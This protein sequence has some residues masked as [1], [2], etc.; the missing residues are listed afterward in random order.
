[1]APAASARAG[2]PARRAAAGQAPVGFV[3]GCASRRCSAEPGPVA[4]DRRLAHSLLSLAG[5]RVSNGAG[6]GRRHRQSIPLASTGTAALHQEDASDGGT[7]AFGC[8]GTRST[9]VAW[10]VIYR[11]LPDN[12]KL[13]SRR[14]ASGLPDIG[15]RLYI[16]VRRSIDGR[17]TAVVGGSR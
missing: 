13:C 9:Y 12:F 17:T 15:V 14:V 2:G 16:F 6:R 3:C 8:G 7:T 1:L 4:R 11:G 5:S 10:T